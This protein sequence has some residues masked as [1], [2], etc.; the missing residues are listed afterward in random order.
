MD[1]THY[2][3]NNLSRKISDLEIESRKLNKEINK[4]L[5]K[6][7]I[8]NKLTFYDEIKFVSN[9]ITLEEGQK[10]KISL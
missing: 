1:K 2:P 7:K 4:F 3:Q 10:I 6:T 5:Q 9:K 8:G